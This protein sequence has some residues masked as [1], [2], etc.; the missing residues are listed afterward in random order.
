MTVAVCMAVCGHT[1]V[2][3]WVALNTPVMVKGVPVGSAAFRARPFLGSPTSATLC[4]RFQPSPQHPPE[5]C[6]SFL[7]TPAASPCSTHRA[8]P[9]ASHGSSWV[10]RLLPLTPSPRLTLLSTA[11]TTGKPPPPLVFPDD[12]LLICQSNISK[13]RLHILTLSIYQRRHKIDKNTLSFFFSCCV[14]ISTDW[15]CNLNKFASPHPL[16]PVSTGSALWLRCFC[17]SSVVCM[18]F[19]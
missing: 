11:Y 7:V 14:L 8:G 19:V 18:F 10:V 1:Q 6:H 17:Y 16:L 9:C 13:W 3:L 5:F 12:P 2:Q 15:C 4:S